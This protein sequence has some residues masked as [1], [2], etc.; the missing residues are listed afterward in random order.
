MEDDIS[1]YHVGM[2]VKVLFCDTQSIR[3]LSQKL[4]DMFRVYCVFPHLG[5]LSKEIEI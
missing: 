3:I 4:L 2:D 1:S 5:N